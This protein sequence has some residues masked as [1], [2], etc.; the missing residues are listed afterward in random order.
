MKPLLDKYLPLDS[1]SSSST[2]LFA[3]RQKDHYSHFILRLAFASTEDLRRRFSR[4]ET[5]LFRLRLISDDLAER[6]AVVSEL[7]LDWWEPVSDEE[8]M[9]FQSELRDTAGGGRKLGQQEEEGW[10]KVNWERVPELVE[11]RR[12]F[13][14][15]GKAYVPM[16]EQASMVIS[17]FTSR[18]EKQLEVSSH[19]Y[20]RGTMRMQ[21]TMHSLQHGPYPD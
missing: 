10:F 7:N 9:Q 17:E 5:M 21:L 3:Q 4:V 14:R 19:R 2:Q 15:A 20:P 18:L 6:T 11:G 8:R 1:S 13:L 16:R 12:A